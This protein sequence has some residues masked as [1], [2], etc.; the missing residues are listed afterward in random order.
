MLGTSRLVLFDP[1]FRSFGPR[2]CATAPICLANA[3]LRRQYQHK[4]GEAR[5]RTLRNGDIVSIL[6][7]LYQFGNTSRYRESH[8]A[9]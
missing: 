9:S 4:A 8:P 1:T 5:R 2:H 7:S 3:E 6:T